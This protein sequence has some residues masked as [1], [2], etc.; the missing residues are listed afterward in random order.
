MH[1]KIKK[2]SMKSRYHE[3]SAAKKKAHGKHKSTHPA[4][5]YHAFEEKEEEKI[6][7]GIHKKILDYKK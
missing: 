3:S 2:Q 6:H 4:K 1:K 7:P 5:S